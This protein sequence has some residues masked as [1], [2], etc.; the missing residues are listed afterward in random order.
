MSP[1]FLVIGAGVA[2]LREAIALMERECSS[3]QEGLPNA[4]LVVRL[5][6]RC[7]VAREESRGAHFRT[8]Y[9]KI[10]P[11]FARHSSIQKDAGITFR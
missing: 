3:E 8:D 5:I 6:A 10:R 2:G 11:E 4:A 7:A 9:P 1:D